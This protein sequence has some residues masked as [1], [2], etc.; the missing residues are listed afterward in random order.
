[1][2]NVLRRI[3]IDKFPRSPVLWIAWSGLLLLIT[4]S[5]CILGNQSP[6]VRLLNQGDYTGAIDALR[7]EEIANPADPSI[8]RDL[9]V[10]LYLAGEHEAARGSLAAAREMKADDVQAVF[11]LGRVLPA[12]KKPLFRG[13]GGSDSL[14][15]QGIGEGRFGFLWAFPIRVPKTVNSCGSAF[16]GL[17]Y[18]VTPL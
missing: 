10:A 8:K 16:F 3:C 13:G 18:E 15:A 12:G 1:M 5:G 2:T 4:S 11:Y 7:S 9:G 17:I 6:G 14:F